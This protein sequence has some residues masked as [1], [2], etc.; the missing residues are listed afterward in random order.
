MKEIH[1]HTIQQG[2]ICKEARR[3]LA[4]G[5]AE[6]TDEIALVYP[7]G[8]VKLKAAIEWAAAHDVNTSISGTPVWVKAR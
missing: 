7:D 4:N 1:I 2:S 5:L 8:R 3:L 6:P